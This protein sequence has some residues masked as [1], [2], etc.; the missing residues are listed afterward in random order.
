MT[1]QNSF[2]LEMEDLFPWFIIS[3][4]HTN[5]LPE[6]RNKACSGSG[7]HYLLAGDRLHAWDHLGSSPCQKTFSAVHKSYL[8]R[9]VHDMGYPNP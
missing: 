9:A 5:I 8:V 1:C 7:R 6:F 3:P 4:I 2:S